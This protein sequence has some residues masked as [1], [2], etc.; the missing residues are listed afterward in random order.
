VEPQSPRAG[1]DAVL[2]FELFCLGRGGTPAVLLEL[3]GVAGVQFCEHPAPTAADCQGP[4]D[5]TGLAPRR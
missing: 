3:G 5:L 1:A 4:T 2:P